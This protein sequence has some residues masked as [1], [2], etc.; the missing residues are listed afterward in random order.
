MR[1]R[2]PLSLLALAFAGMAH[3]EVPA[4]QDVP[5]APGTIRLEVDAT[6]LSQ[7]IFRVK[8]TIPVQPGELTLLYPVWIPGGHSPRGAIAS[9]SISLSSIR[10]MRR[11]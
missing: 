11:R 5:Y 6:N 9:S 8:E 4:P 1:C 7:R 10:A 2:I 3:A